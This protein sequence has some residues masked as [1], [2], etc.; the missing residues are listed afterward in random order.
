MRIDEIVLT[1]VL[2]FNKYFKKMYDRNTPF[3]SESKSRFLLI[4]NKNKFSLW[5]DKTE[6]MFVG[7]VNKEYAMSIF[8]KKM[9]DGY[10]VKGSFIDPKYQ[11]FSLLK[12]AYKMIVEHVGKL[13][14]D[15]S[16]SKAAYSVWLG[17]EKDSDVEVDVFDT[18]TKTYTSMTADEIPTDSE[19][20]IFC[21]SK[22]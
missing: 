12:T 8:V 18:K 16:V 21:L 13:Y 22:K 6:K 14:S 9:K 20:Y 1:S 2:P 17:L 5:F 15:T 7:F 4:S 3:D 10:Q 11:G 19:R